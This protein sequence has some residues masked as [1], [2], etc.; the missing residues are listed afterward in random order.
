MARTFNL[1]WKHS[2]VVEELG[3]L[4]KGRRR[5]RSSALARKASVIPRSLVRIEIHPEKRPWRCRQGRRISG[6]S[7]RPPSTCPGQRKNADS[8]VNPGCFLAPLGGGGIVWAGVKPRKIQTRPPRE[9]YRRLL[10]LTN[11]AIMSDNEMVY[12]SCA[13]TG[14]NLIGPSSPGMNPAWSRRR[15]GS[16]WGAGSFSARS[17]IWPRRIATRLSSRR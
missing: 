14:N 3:R 9:R 4:G 7:L 1:S 8:A 16:S 17:R 12:R 6:G 13:G 15:N 10:S 5:A 2:Q 11:H